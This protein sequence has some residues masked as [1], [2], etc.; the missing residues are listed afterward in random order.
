MPPGI[1]QVD[2]M[3][4]HYM[5]VGFERTKTLGAGG[6]CCDG[7]YAM[8][9]SCKWDPKVRLQERNEAAYP[10][11]IEN[12]RIPAAVYGQ[13]SGLLDRLLSRQGRSSS[14]IRVRILFLHCPDI[15]YP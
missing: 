2:Y 5:N 11:P 4:S 6:C 13:H 7:K 14:L 1:C 9:G 15:F 8:C 12:E 3:I 10:K